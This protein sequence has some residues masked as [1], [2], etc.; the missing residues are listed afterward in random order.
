MMSSICDISAIPRR[1]VGGVAEENGAVFTLIAEFGWEETKVTSHIPA[2][3]LKA[4]RPALILSLITSHA[5]LQHCDAL[6]AVRQSSDYIQYI[7]PHLQK[8]TTTRMGL[9]NMQRAAPRHDSKAA[10]GRCAARWNYVFFPKVKLEDQNLSH[11]LAILLM[12]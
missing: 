3:G 12:W 4:A 1:E 11:I 9:A 7:F 2:S 6:S 10:V 8:S 5:S